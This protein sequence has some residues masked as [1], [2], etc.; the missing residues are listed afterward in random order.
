MKR[1]KI[2]NLDCIKGL[3]EI[4]NNSVDLIIADTPYNLNKNFG[5]WNENEHK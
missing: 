1:N 2:H 3:K 4:P 5:I